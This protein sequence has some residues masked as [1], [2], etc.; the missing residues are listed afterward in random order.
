MPPSARGRR[1]VGAYYYRGRE[2]CLHHADG[3]IIVYAAVVKHSYFQQLDLLV[4]R[5][6]SYEVP[7]E[8]GIKV[9]ID[10]SNFGL[11]DWDR[12]S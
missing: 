1:H 4:S 12:G 2:L 6:Q 8:T 7:P 9:R 3:E 11:L 10:V 5:A